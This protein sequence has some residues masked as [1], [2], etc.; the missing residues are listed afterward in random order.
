M[1]A[2][3]SLSQAVYSLQAISGTIG[4]IASFWI[5]KKMS[6]LP[7]SKTFPGFV[8]IILA[9]LDGLNGLFFLLNSLQSKAFGRLFG[10]Q[11]SLIG[12]DEVFYVV[13]S[14]IWDWS[15]ISSAFVSFTLVWQVYYILYGGLT[16]VLQTRKWIIFLVVIFTP[17][18]IFFGVYSIVQRVPIYFA[19]RYAYL[20]TED[21]SELCFS[22]LCYWI[23]PDRAMFWL[24]ALTTITNLI[25]STITHLNLT[26]RISPKFNQRKPNATQL[27][28]MRLVMAFSI[29]SVSIWI[30][31]LTIDIFL[32]H[33]TKENLD[34]GDV[35][36]WIIMFLKM[37][38]SPARGLWHAMALV[39]TLQLNVN[40][41]FV[42]E[43]PLPPTPIT[44]TP[45]FASKKIELYCG[46]NSCTSIS[47]DKWKF[48]SIVNPVNDT[49]EIPVQSFRY[50]P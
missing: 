13:Y 17:I 4:F 24:I 28:I 50:D 34:S 47:I 37:T 20:V 26:G 25:I 46:N 33:K 45:I 32:K 49:M 3:A 30:P 29:A 10:L 19:G 12:T 39:Y 21:N 5:I 35:I 7:F 1:S 41:N 16:S 36:Y 38:L 14:N 48:D 27:L 15:Q 43:I 42:N 11:T 8:V 6:T 40:E 22:V 2:T 23:T 9:Y 44:K 18:P 31:Y